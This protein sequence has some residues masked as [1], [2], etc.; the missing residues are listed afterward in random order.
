LHRLDREVKLSTMSTHV[1][2]DLRRPEGPAK[3]TGRARY[4]A[5]LAVE[6]AWVGAAVRSPV[7]CGTLTG[8]DVD[9]GFDPGSVVLVRP[10]NIPGD[11]VMALIED[12]QPVLCA[13]DVMHFGEPPMLVAAPD[14]PTLAV[15]LAAIRPVIEEGVPELDME[16]SE[17]VFKRIAIDKG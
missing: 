16:R 7:V 11:N 9:P 4:V 10:D 8:F 14:R 1:G 17:R 13:R 12:D 3:V 15:A 2:R 6:G 5:D